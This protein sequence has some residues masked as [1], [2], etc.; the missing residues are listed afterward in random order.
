[1]IPYRS[2]D[3]VGLVC[4][5][6]GTA[7]GLAIGYKFYRPVQIIEAA[8]PEEKLE[9]L[10]VVVLQ[11]LPEN[12]APPVSKEVKKAAKKVG[13]KLERVQTIT[14]QPKPSEGAPAGCSCD[15]IKLEVGTVDTGDGKRAVVH[16][17]NATIINGTDIPLE[18]YQAVKDLKWEVGAIVPMENPKGVGAY[19]S[20]KAGP[21]SV[22]IQASKPF[23][24][25]GYTAMATVG[26]RF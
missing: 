14:I 18:P 12:I 1:M 10:N 16:T 11:R 3:I 19:V 21:F 25:E 22:G 17:D 2:H 8:A 24:N 15:E 7:L 13:G 20:R 4:L 23:E 6:I 26:I 5:L 9:D